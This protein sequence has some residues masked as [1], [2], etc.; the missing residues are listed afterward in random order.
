MDRTSS[1]SKDNWYLELKSHPEL[2]NNPFS[3]LTKSRKHLSH[4]HTHTHTHKVLLQLQYKNNIYPNKFKIRWSSPMQAGSAANATRSVSIR[5]CWTAPIADTL[6]ARSAMCLA[7]RWARREIGPSLE[8]SKIGSR[9]KQGGLWE[10]R[11]GKGRGERDRNY[12]WC[13]LV[14]AWCFGR[15]KKDMGRCSWGNE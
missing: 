9:M 4:A 5:E 8:A 10:G 6:D 2:S 7:L 1:T 15:G 14:E 13:K 3:L 11:E 12:A